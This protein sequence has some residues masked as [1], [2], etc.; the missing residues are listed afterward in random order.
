MKIDTTRVLSIG[1]VLCFFSF[2]ISCE[3]AHSIENYFNHINRAEILIVC[4]QL[5]QAL[6][7]YNYAFRVRKIPFAIDLYN[8]AMLSMDL[9]RKGDVMSALLALMKYKGVTLKY[10]QRHHKFKEIELYLKNDI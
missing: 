7:E 10:I 4:N 9:D 2:L 8:Y 3:R 6:T 1:L 5:D